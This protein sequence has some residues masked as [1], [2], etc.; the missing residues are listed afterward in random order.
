MQHKLIYILSLYII[1]NIG[2]YVSGRIQLPVYEM[3]TSGVFSV[4]QK[5]SSPEI[6]VNFSL[7]HPTIR[8]LFDEGKLI[9]SSRSK[10]A[11]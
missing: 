7:I 11:H 9:W 10:L 5:G 3:S 6:D 1:F 8:N 2:F 4:H